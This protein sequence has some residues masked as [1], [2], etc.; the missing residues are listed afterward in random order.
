MK[1]FITAAAVF[2]LT[3][4][5]EKTDNGNMSEASVRVVETD[6]SILTNEIQPVIRREAGKRNA[7]R[8]H[9]RKHF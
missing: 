7:I 3:A 1:R 2:A 8:Q 4:C 6:P 9:E 5:N